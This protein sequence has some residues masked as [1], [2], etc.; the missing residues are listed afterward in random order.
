MSFFFSLSNTFSP[1]FFFLSL[2]LFYKDVCLGFHFSKNTLLS[3]FFCSVV[4]EDEKEQKK[5]KM[6]K[7]TKKGLI[8][9][10]IL[11]TQNKR[12]DTHTKKKRESF[13]IDI[14]KMMMTTMS[15]VQQKGLGGRPSTRKS[16]SSAK[17]RRWRSSSFS[18]SYS[19]RAGKNSG[20]RERHHCA[21]R[22]TMTTTSADAK[23]DFDVDASSGRTKKEKKKD[24][25]GRAAVLTTLA[26]SPFAAFAQ[27]ALAKDG[28]F[29]V[30]EGRSAALVHPIF[31]GIMYVTTIYAGYVGW[32]W[33]KVRTV[34]EEIQ[35]LK[36]SGADP[37]TA[38][39]E[40]VTPNPNQT[41]I[42]ELTK[43][44]KELIAGNYKEKHF[45]AGSLLLAFG[46]VLAIEGGMNTY[47]RVGKLFP[48][49][50]LYAGMGIVALWAAAA[51]LVPE[52]QRG[53]DKARS[54][55]I[56]LN[57]VNVALFTWQIPTGLEI[58]GKVFQFTSWP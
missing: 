56:A 2:F 25:E 23:E 7:N 57:A 10:V 41:K 54:A 26:A 11:V 17:R 40:A 4:D 33:R 51:G 43:E 38:N 47:I 34:G 21:C 3:S 22:G 29:G 6:E 36:K 12:E 32:Q 19:F 9:D 16:S 28:E 35:E 15:R 13:Y 53:N 58:V 20:E 5:K 52:M 50:H 49:P 31:L 1:L 44:R 27:E 46:T 24:I 30:L 55:H 42:D 18:S 8:G 39:G 14:E 45:N 37:E 48:G